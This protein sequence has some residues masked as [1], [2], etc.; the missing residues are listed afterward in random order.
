MYPSGHIIILHGNLAPD[1]AVAKVAGLKQR[2][3]RG[4]AKVFDGEEAC[5]AAIQDRTIKHGDVLVIRGELLKRY[6][7]AVIY[8]HRACWQRKEVT[9]ADRDQHPCDRSGGIDNTQERRLAPLTP[10]EEASPP[11]YWLAD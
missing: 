7:T 1:G 10:E 2:S 6:P 8:A 11:R 9:A 5:F 3:I 4:P